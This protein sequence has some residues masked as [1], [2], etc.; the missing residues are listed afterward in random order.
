MV[1]LLG[2][3]AEIIYAHGQMKSAE[4]EDRIRLFYERKASVMVSTSIIENSI[5]LPF[6]NTLI[7]I[8]ADNFGLSQLYQLRGRVGRSD[9][10][11]Y[12]YFTVREGKALTENAAKRLEAL[13]EYTDL[14]SGFKVA[15][16][17]LD[18][19]GAGNVL[20]REQSGHM[21]KVGYDMYCRMIKEAIEE[22]QGENDNGKERNRAKYRGRSY[23]A[24][25]VYKFASRKVEI[26]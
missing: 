1:N 7:V 16:R 5:D 4:L 19:R 10:P 11:A 22:A 15:L 13:M 14:G 21:E 9:V 26:L 23:L 25:R 6:A 17:D 12:A 18:I 2:N 8:D 3:E 20:G 24:R